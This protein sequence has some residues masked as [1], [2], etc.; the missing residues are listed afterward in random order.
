MIGMA[1]NGS[2]YTAARMQTMRNLAVSLSVPLGTQQITDKTGLAGTYDFKLVYS[3]ADL[4]GGLG[5]TRSPVTSAAGPIDNLSDPT[6]DLF[7]ALEKQLGLKLTKGKA[8]LEVIV[9]DHI[10]KVP[11][12]N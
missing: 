1:N 7:T 12:E 3:T 10:E 6:P 8:P 9:I 4:P 11:T 5:V 2:M